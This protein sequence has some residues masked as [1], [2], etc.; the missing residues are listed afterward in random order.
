MNFSESDTH[1]GT[2]DKI[3]VLRNFSFIVFLL[4]SAH[5]VVA[6]FATSERIT[7]NYLLSFTFLMSIG[8]ASLFWTMIHHAT[9]ATWSAAVRRIPETLSLILL[10]GVLCAIP[11]FFGLNTLYEWTHE[12]VHNAAY[13]NKPFFII[14]TL[15]YF[16]I[17][18]LLYFKIVKPS[19]IQDKT[20]NLELTHHMWKW[21]CVGLFLFAVTLHLASVDWLM[22]L[23]SHWFSTIFG[24]YYF[25]GSAVCGLSTIIILTIILKK[26]G[27]L[28]FVN[29]NHFHDLGKLLFGLNVFWAYIAFSQYM[30]IWYGHLPEETVFFYQRSGDAWKNISL[31]LPIG[32]FV[33][34]FFL[35]VSRGAKRNLLTLSVGA[36]WLIL[37]HYVDL[38]WLIF[39]V[40]N[41]EAAPF[42]LPEISGF[43]WAVSLVFS[44][45]LW[46]FE[47]H[48]L[49]PLKDPRLQESLE[50]HQ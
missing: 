2:N 10:I 44:L 30:L 3:K 6:S 21:S 9:K 48:A 38:Y 33:I 36:T 20:G 49:V 19:M 17:W 50:F 4:S 29:E 25:A 46:S 40:F 18:S 41:K 13:L 24:V 22:S 11:L 1:I 23:D 16:A 12:K 39:P 35:L 28:S 8:L 47:K 32:H 37:M 45:T 42:G 26:F 31:I 43:M 27:Y 7:F 15:T 14:R 34:P 5:Y